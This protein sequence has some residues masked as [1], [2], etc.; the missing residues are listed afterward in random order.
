[1]AIRKIDFT[2]I[3]W[4]AKKIFPLLA[5]MRSKIVTKISNLNEVI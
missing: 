3:L 4:M 1:M 2:V 5:T